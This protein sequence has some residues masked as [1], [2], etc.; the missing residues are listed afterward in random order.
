MEM[1]WVPWVSMDELLINNC[2][3]RIWVIAMINNYG[4]EAL[5]NEELFIALC[6]YAFIKTDTERNAGRAQIYHVLEIWT[7]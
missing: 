6:F 4:Q 2:C 7:T 5:D 1:E 3:K